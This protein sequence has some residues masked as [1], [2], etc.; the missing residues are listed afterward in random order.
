MEK[1]IPGKENNKKCT[2]RTQP[3]CR[4]RSV[5]IS[6][7]KF[8]KSLQ[9]GETIKA[10]SLS[11]GYF[12]KQ[13]AHSYSNMRYW[14]YWEALFGAQTH[15]ILKKKSTFYFPPCWV[16]FHNTELSSPA[17]KIYLLGVSPVNNSTPISIKFW[18]RYP[19]VHPRIFNIWSLL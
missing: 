10:S 9:Y 7:E 16:P 6:Y 14:W 19:G 15:G 2:F 12:K 18:N 13:E 5:S 11:P 3:I 4:L 8:F 1:C 17:S